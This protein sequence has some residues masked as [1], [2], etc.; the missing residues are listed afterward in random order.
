MEKAYKHTKYVQKFV[1]IVQKLAK[2]P[3]I[4]QKRQKPFL[5]CV[6]TTKNSTPVEISTGGPAAAAIFFHLC[7]SYKGK[8]QK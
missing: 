5:K 7:P 3:K 8:T 2:M 4:A 6:K 1:K